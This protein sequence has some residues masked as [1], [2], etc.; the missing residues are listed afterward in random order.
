[1]SEEA[2]GELE[3]QTEL[4]QKVLADKQKEIT[5]VKD[6]LRQEKEEAIRVYCDSDALLAKR[7]ICRRL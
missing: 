5:E 6:R 4:L 3:K 2:R 1:M 7:F